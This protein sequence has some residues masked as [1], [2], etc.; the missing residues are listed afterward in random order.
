MHLFLSLLLHGLEVRL[1]MLDQCDRISDTSLRLALFTSAINKKNK[2][3]ER[4]ISGSRPLM[5]MMYGMEFEIII[6][7]DKK[8]RFGIN[9]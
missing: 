7:D 4:Y 3:H 9:M 1:S 6:E 8:F 2:V 5:G